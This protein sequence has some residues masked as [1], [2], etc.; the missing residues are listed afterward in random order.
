MGE[1]GDVSTLTGKELTEVTQ[2]ED[3]TE[4]TDYL[5]YITLCYM[6]HTFSN[7]DVTPKTEHKRCV[8][9][10]GSVS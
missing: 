9:C 7:L 6:Y 4:E 3:E 8:V 1:I 5:N 2:R 10:V